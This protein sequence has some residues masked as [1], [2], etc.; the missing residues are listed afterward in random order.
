MAQKTPQVILLGNGINR[1]FD[2]TSWNGLLHEIANEE[3]RAQNLDKLRCPMPL[4]AIL[5]TSDHVDKSLKSYVKTHREEAFG[6]VEKEEH[7][8]VLKEILAIGADHILTTNYSYEPEI[9]ALGGR[10]SVS[11]YA[12][13][14]VMML[15]TR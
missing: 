11:E 7:T 5:V 1:A 12:L 3:Y 15:A 13:K 4:K 8:K 14:K 2:G 6:K 9:A 10:G